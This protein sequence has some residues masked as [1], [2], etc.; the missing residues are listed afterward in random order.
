MEALL[1]LAFDNLSSY[2]GLKIRKGLRQVEGLLA[3]ICLSTPS[4]SSSSS[5]P[6][7]PN[8]H[9]RSDSKL[10]PDPSDAPN[11]EHD[12]PDR[13]SL[14]DLGDDPAF[15]EFFKLQEGFEWNVALRLINTLDRLMAKSSDGQNDL[16]ILSALDAIQGVLLL[17]P[18]SKSLFSREQ[19][20]NLLLD[21]LEPV[22]CPA[23][24]SATLLTVVVALIDTPTNTRTFEALDGLLTVT[25]L[26]KSRS[27]SRE[28]KLKLVE[29]LYFYLMPEVPSIPW[30]D[31]RDSVPAMLQRSP[32]KLA[33]AFGHKRG[34][35]R[36]D[37]SVSASARSRAGSESEGTLST[38]EKQALLG[39]HL[40]SVEDLVKDLRTSTP[41]G[42][43][44]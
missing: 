32:S 5:S 2:D 37:S 33:S 6:A 19:Y 9:K 36:A 42:G 34:H 43:V 28:V 18:P 7:K 15:R 27:T 31:A 13:K 44:L 40:S 3:Q 38:E 4:R 35:S 41:F 8:G 21:L 20:M 22:N 25:S 16:L 26:F 11:D 10:S 17:H 1:S 14:A 39:R 12:G 23:I 29:F 30:A 24:Q